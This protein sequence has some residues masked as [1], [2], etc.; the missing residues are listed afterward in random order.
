MIPKTF[1]DW[2]YCIE[3][4]CKIEL[5][6]KF[7][8]ERLEI[9]RDLKNQESQKFIALYGHNHYKNVIDWLQQFVNE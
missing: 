8:I 7:V 9:Y 4:D 5:T 3:K 1:E 2:K 6:K